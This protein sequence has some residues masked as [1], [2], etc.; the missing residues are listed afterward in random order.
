MTH[1]ESDAHGLSLNTI[2]RYGDRRGRR[3]SEDQAIMELRRNGF[4]PD[5]SVPTMVI[6]HRNGTE[7]VIRHWTRAHVP[8]EHNHAVTR[9]T[10]AI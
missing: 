8:G 10:F 9:A 7:T 6:S 5:T 3:L 4:G 1:N 2:L